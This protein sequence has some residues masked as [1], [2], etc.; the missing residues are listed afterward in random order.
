MQRRA[1]T[2]ATTAAVARTISRLAPH[3]AASPPEPQALAAGTRCSILPQTRPLTAPQVNRIR[4][5]RLQ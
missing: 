4:R 5:A 2:T 1:H 3:T